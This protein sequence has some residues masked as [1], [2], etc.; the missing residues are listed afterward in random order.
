MPPPAPRDRLTREAEAILESAS[1]NPAAPAVLMAYF[2]KAE[3]AR[4]HIPMPVACQRFV[5]VKDMY[6]SATWGARRTTIQGMLHGLGMKHRGRLHDGRDDARNIARIVKRLLQRPCKEQTLETA[7][8]SPY[9]PW[10]T[11]WNLDVETLRSTASRAK[12]QAL[13]RRQQPPENLTRTEAVRL[14][15]QD[16]AERIRA[17]S[18][19]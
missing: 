6:T 19:A 7:D 2:L 18:C 15:Q 5:D 10:E 16:I 8:T 11:Q 17:A 13:S 9:A 1:Y 3:V 14:L 4:K 12:W